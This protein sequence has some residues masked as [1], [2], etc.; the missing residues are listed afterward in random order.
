MRKGNLSRGLFAKGARHMNISKDNRKPQGP[1]RESAR[2]SSTSGQ[3]R[4]GT[5]R[6]S[7]ASA[8]GAATGSGETRKG[9][10][11]GRGPWEVLTGVGE[12]LCWPNSDRRR[13]SKAVGLVL[14]RAPPV[15]KQGRH[16]AAGVR[17]GVP[18]LAA[19]LLAPPV[20]P[21]HESTGQTAAG[22]A[23]GSAFTHG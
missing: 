17:F 8:F 19:H 5:H 2:A 23:A 1:N 4:T 14:C 9:E 16:P 6:A 18:E 20:L 21:H 22:M 11:R 10:R 12:V 7:A 15:A 13:G 3:R